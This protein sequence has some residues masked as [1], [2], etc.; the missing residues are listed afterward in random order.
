MQDSLRRARPLLGT[1]VE[2]SVPHIAGRDPDTVIDEAFDAIAKVHNLMSFHDPDSDVSRLN[3][4]ASVHSVEVHPWTLEVLKTAIELRDRSCG[5][6][7]ISVAP[8]L[9]DLGL[10]PDHVGRGSLTSVGAPG[11]NVKVLPD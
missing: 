7:D 6:F 10:L 9:Q 4:E 11:E 5:L 1:F 8:A 3:R 2:I